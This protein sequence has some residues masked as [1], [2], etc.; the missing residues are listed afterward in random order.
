MNAMTPPVRK[1][2]APHVRDVMTP[3]PVCVNTGDSLRDVARLLDE[4]EISGAPVVDDQ[5]RVVGVVSR[6][7]L[8]HG[9]IEGPQGARKDEDWL[10]LLT[11]D[12][13]RSVDVAA[14]RLGVVDDWMSIE[15]VV[16]KPDE[17]LA[18]IARRMA[19]SRVHRIIVV[20]AQRR[21]IGI[22]TTL[23]LLRNYPS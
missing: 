22:V 16:A 3:E 2:K 12:S 1:R 11:A 7:D 6:T 5:Q 20:D 19:A 4:Y 9:L 15:P 8:L 13:G 18:T 14:A 17:S 10:D 23:D 21:P